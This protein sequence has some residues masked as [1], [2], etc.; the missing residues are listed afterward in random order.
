MLS[1]AGETP[2]IRQRH[3]LMLGKQSQEPN[4]RVTSLLLF[5]VPF[6]ARDQIVSKVKAAG[7][8]RVQKAVRNVKAPENDLATAHIDVSLS[9]VGPIVPSDEPVMRRW[10][11]R[12]FVTM[13]RNASSP[14]EHFGLPA[15][16]TVIMGS[17]VGL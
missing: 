1:G 2:N 8:V 5:D 9:N 16:Q 17:Q 13:A 4:G 3:D 15:D 11:K 6:A 14:I 10:R 12:L 7:T